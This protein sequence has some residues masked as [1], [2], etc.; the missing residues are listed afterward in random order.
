[1]GVKYHEVVGGFRASEYMLEDMRT[2][3]K[4]QVCHGVEFKLP[5]IIEYVHKGHV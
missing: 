2:M 5:L 1:M 4:N 3:P